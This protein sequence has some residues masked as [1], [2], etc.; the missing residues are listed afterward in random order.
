[1]CVLRVCR[2]SLMSKKSSCIISTT[3]KPLWVDFFL[4]ALTGKIILWLLKKVLK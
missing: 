4:F 2:I 3:E 1:M